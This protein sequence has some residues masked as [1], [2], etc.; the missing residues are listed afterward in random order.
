[1]LLPIQEF[2]LVTLAD[3]Q[4]QPSPP[5]LHII[6]P[7]P[8]VEI[9]ILVLVGPLVAQVILEGPVEDVSVEQDQ[10]SLQLLVVAPGAIE[11]CALAE[12]VRPSALLL[13][14][15]EVAHVFVFIHELEGALSVGQVVYELS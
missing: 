6:P 7:L 15:V 4:D 13:P 2:S 9:A 14:L 8:V 11:D 12:V 3:L 5:V 1:M 10:L